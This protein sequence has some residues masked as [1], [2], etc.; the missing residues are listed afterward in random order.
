MGKAMG[1]KQNELGAIAVSQIRKRGIHFVGGVAGLALNVTKYGSR[2]WILRYQI[3]GKRRDK[4]LGGYPDV[5]LS[6]AREAARNARAQIA[7]GLDPVDEAKK[8]RSQ[9]IASRRVALTFSEA[10][11]QYIDTHEASWR[12]PKHC[13]QWR[14]TIKDYAYQSIGGMQ[15]NDIG[16]NDVLCVLNPIWHDKTETA[17]RLRGRL[18]SI[19]DWAYA[20]GYRTKPN[21]AKWKGLLDNLLPAPR[22]ITK[23]K[24]HRALHYRDLPEFMARLVKM[25]GAAPIALAFTILTACRSGEVRGATR[26]EFDLDNGIW[27]IPASRM[28]AGKEHRV[29]LSTESLVIA[30]SQ[31]EI[32]PNKYLFPSLRQAASSSHEGAPMSD[33]ALNAVLR[34]MKVDAV[35]HGFRST[36]RD[37]CAEQTDYSNHVA[38]MALAHT[39]GNKVEAAYRRGDLLEKRSQLMK[40]WASYAFSQIDIN[41]LAA[42]RFPAPPGDV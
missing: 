21:P 27:T 42:S 11:K 24:H 29:P 10:A 35:P 23:T 34:R 4:G 30:L 22:K 3:D 32:S 41:T 14:N 19:F 26:N 33:M 17:S 16:V 18:E 20:M 8:L 38:E 36:F 28:K 5:T 25:D 6:A 12:N 31:A 39:I 13:Q 2:S 7:R 9:L 40:E 15:L 1:K 37:W